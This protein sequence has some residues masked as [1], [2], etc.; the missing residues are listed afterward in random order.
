MRIY[1]IPKDSYGCCE[2]TNDS[3]RTSLTKKLTMIG[4]DEQN[5]GVPTND[6]NSDGE[7]SVESDAGGY[8]LCKE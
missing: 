2:S 5:A 8:V 1:F 6:G 3:G 4:R 7:Y